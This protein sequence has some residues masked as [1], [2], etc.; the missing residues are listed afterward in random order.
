MPPTNAQAATSVVDIMATDF[1]FKAPDTF[2]AGLVKL[3]LM[4]H[5]QDV[6]HAQVLRLNDGVSFDQ[7][8]STFEAQGDAALRLVSVDG[9][10]GALNPAKSAE[11]TV[12]LTP[13][14]Y[15]LPALWL[16][17]TACRTWPRAC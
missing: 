12:D 2:P 3:R 14:S 1:A 15:V 11:V 16:A 17:Q 9:G 5:G 10:P 8:M 7:L 6:H 13:G 4:N